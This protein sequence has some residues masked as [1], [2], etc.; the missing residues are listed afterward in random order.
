M[1]KY[2]EK[3]KA[4][5]DERGIEAEHLSFDRS[6]HSVAEA[7]RTVGA[8]PEDFIKS[9]CMVDQGG[10]AIVA[11][12]KGEDQAST[13]RVAR[14]LGIDRPRVAS[15]GEIM[16]LTGFPLGGTPGFG[17]DATF[18]VDPRVLEKE[19]VYLGGGSEKALVRMSTKEL[20]RAN[21]ARVVRVRK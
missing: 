9:I 6:C 21:Q 2:E 20:V 1:R 5:I 17:F 16:G 4:I 14:A 18:L 7:A 15:P 19:T 13:S 10:L 8:A 3:L 12:V 11:I